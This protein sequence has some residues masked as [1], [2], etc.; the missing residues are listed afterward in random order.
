M[1]ELAPHR[2]NSFLANLTQAMRSTA[3]TA[4]VASIERCRIDAKAYVEQVQAR[5]VDEAGALRSDSEADVVTIR[6]RAKAQVDRVRVETEERVARRL[7]LLQ[8]ELADY[9]SSIE[10]EVVRVQERVA[11][12]QDEVARFFEEIQGADPSALANMA[13]EMPSPP[14]FDPER[15]ALATEPEK[16]DREID[17]EPRAEMV[18]PGGPRAPSGGR[19]APARGALAPGTLSGA[20]AV[21]GRLYSE[22]YGEVERLRQIGDEDDA[23]TLLFDIVA[24]AEAESQAD[25]SPVAPR[26]YE[27]LAAI[28]LG[29]NDAEEEQ[30]ILER[31]ARQEHA[32]GVV[33]S[34]LQERLKTLRKSPRR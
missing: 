28:Y 32:P 17:S 25:G 20:G 27:E 10:L 29:R 1:S 24:G 11:A 8:Q 4:R 21:R 33:A 15:E 18:P 14:E 31:F 9:N 34:R 5:T 13:Y 6:A 16:L 26:A 22:W 19:V 23:I 30:S 12:F 7:D 2:L 3:E